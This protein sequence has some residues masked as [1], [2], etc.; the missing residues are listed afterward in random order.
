MDA[1]S[2]GMIG[3]LTGKE[4]AEVHLPLLI[5][6][7]TSSSSISNLKISPSTSLIDINRHL[8]GY[9]VNILISNNSSRI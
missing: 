3:E 9:A 8:T 4:T 2:S 5:F 6:S 1:K 7:L